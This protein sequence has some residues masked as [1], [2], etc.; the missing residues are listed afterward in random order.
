MDLSFR[1]PF[2]VTVITPR[3]DFLS[4]SNSPGAAMPLAA[5]ALGRQSYHAPFESIAGAE[6]R[7]YYCRT[8]DGAEVDLVFERHGKLRLAAEIK[9]KRNI[10]GADFEG[11]RSFADAHPGVPRA[12]V[13]LVPEPHRLEGVEVLPYRRFFE[14]LDS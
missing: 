6:T 4:I 5:E 12:V 14:R 11:L 3:D 1:F 7:L 2:T 8:H 10:A 9:S 13:A